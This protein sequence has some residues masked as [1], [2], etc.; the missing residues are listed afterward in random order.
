MPIYHVNKSCLADEISVR[1]N[2]VSLV[3]EDRRFGPLV[4]LLAHGVSILFPFV[5]IPLEYK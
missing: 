4:L 1:E 5:L 3:R 2:K